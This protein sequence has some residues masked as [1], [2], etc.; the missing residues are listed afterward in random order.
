MYMLEHN[1]EK[2][3]IFCFAIEAAEL[4]NTNT[5]RQLA[6]MTKKTLI[7]H[8]FHHQLFSDFFLP[9]IKRKQEKLF[10]AFYLKLELY[11]K[12]LIAQYPCSSSN[13][14]NLVFSPFFFFFSTGRKFSLN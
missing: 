5:T 8:F 10:G 11:M 1:G 13:F 9:F 14:L 3:R 12:L 2:G 7:Y 6:T 4:C